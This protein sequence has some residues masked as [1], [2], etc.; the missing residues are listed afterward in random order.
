[1]DSHLHLPDCGLK[2]MRSVR[3]EDG[4]AVIVDMMLEA[5]QN[6]VNDF[7]A[8]LARRLAEKGIQ[9][10]KTWL[11]EGVLGPVTQECNILL[12][13]EPIGFV[14]AA[15]NRTFDPRLDFSGQPGICTASG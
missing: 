13:P 5:D 7:W 9:K 3:L 10:I 12:Q 4:Q 15:V 11:P 2:A 6:T 1:M 8:Q 14:P